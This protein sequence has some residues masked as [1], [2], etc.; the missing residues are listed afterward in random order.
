MGDSVMRQFVGHRLRGG[1]LAAVAVFVG[2]GAGTD[3]G[4]TCQLFAEKDCL[5]L[6]LFAP[7]H[8]NF[9]GRDRRDC[10]TSYYGVNG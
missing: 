2:E 10:S 8:G 1:S 5:S 4:Q 9:C 7:G 3:M 6:F